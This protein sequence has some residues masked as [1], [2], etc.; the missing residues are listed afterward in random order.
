MG[1]VPVGIIVAVLGF[2][3]AGA[4]LLEA[5]YAGGRQAFEPL[6]AAEERCQAFRPPPD[7]ASTQEWHDCV[8][9]EMVKS[10]LSAAAP[11]LLRAGAA[12]PLL[13]GGAALAWSAV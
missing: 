9:R 12:S 10:P 7:V 13:V 1:W 8:Q 11:W 3:L 2:A 4:L 5:V 6:S